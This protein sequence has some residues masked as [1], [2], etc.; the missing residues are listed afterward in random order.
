MAANVPADQSWVILTKTD[1]PKFQAIWEPS[2]SDV[3]RIIHDARPYL[4]KLMKTTYSDFERERITQILPKWDKYVCQVVGHTEN[5]KKLIHLNFLPKNGI[6][7]HG[8]TDWRHQYIAVDDG[9]ADYWTIE[10]DVNAK[11]FLDFAPNSDV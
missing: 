7:D 6:W 8:S 10:Y 4:E 9:G 5:G 2:E 11:V 1:L 3:P